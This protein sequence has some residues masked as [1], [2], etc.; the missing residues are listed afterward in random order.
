MTDF[1]Q[2]LRTLRS[3]RKL[4]QARV[5]ELLHVSPRVYTRWENGDAV[6]LFATVVKIADILNVTLDELAGRQ[7]LAAGEARIKN[8]E[9]HR[10]Y[11]KVDLLPDE[12]QKA[13]LVVLGSLVKSSGMSRL[14]AE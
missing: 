8:P 13:L 6:P 7:E 3:D 10:L 1:H 11:K 5:A 4:A 14:M 12:D 9:L 2:R